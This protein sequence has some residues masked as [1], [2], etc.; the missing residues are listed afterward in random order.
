MPAPSRRSPSTTSASRAPT[1]ASPSPPPRGSSTASPPSKPDV[2]VAELGDGILGEY[3]VQDILHDAELTRVGA[4]YVMAAPD[5]VACWGAVELMRREFDLP[6]TV[7]TG[8][9]TDNEVGRVY[10]TGSSACRRTTR[11]AMRRGCSA[12]S[13]AIRDWSGRGPWDECDGRRSRRRHRLRSLPASRL[14]PCHDEE[15]PSSEPPATPA[16]SCSASCSS[17]PRWPSAS[18]PAGARRGSRSPRCIR[19]S[20]P[21]TDARFSGADGRRGGARTRRR[22]PGL[23]HGESSQ[24][25]RGGVRCG[26]GP[27][28]RPRGRLP[29]ADLRLYERFYGAHPA[30]GAGRALHLRR[31]PTSLGGELR[32]ATR[33][34]RARLLRD[35]GAAGALSAGARGPRRR[36]IALR[37]HRIER[38]RGATASRR[39]TTPCGRTTSS[40][41][42]CWATGTRPRCCSA[43][44][45]GPAGPTRPRG[46]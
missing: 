2:I 8:P 22:V 14:S 40:P 33:H 41:T 34:R 19:R 7:I 15:S 21:L 46:S 39:P 45:S 9:A 18:R 27:G 16:A 13:A 12:W 28:R 3:G 24:R 42:R 6:I 11:G 17:I 44:G 36:A 29:G 5:P 10:V 37:R 26:A 4:A 1:P 43:G 35:G 20:P 38:R 32:G 23:E 30:P 25:G 31:W